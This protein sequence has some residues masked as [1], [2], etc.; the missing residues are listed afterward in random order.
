MLRV[1]ERERERERSWLVK[2]YAMACHYIRGWGKDH[3]QCRSFSSGNYAGR[4][5]VHVDPEGC[6]LGGD[7]L[8]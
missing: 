2:Y 5:V 3:L 7:T 1:R 4:R 8:V 6:Q